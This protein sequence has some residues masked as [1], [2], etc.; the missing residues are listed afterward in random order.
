MK[1]DYNY[2]SHFYQGISMFLYIRYRVK[3]FERKSA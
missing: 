2:Y 3:N 1:L